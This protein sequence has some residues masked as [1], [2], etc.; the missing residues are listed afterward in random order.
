MV[1]CIQMWLIEK[2]N[3]LYSKATGPYYAGITKKSICGHLS[4][5]CPGPGG[6][7]SF[8]RWA[9]RGT[10]VLIRDPRRYFQN[11]GRPRSR[12]DPTAAPP[13]PKGE[14]GGK[15][16]GGPDRKTEGKEIDN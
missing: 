3:S 16:T 8:L 13:L 12:S 7:R 5:L 15:T 9:S 4:L 2:K 6:V 1:G 14:R 10:V 11:G